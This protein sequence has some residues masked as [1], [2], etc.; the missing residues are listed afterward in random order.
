MT[1]N[2]M[3]GVRRWRARLALT[4]CA[5]VA[6]QL[7]ALQS[8]SPRGRAPIVR[9]ADGFEA[10][11]GEALVQFRD[12]PTAAR[13]RGPLADYVDAA[14]S[15]SV[16]RRGLHRFRSRTFDVDALVA[17]LRTQPDVVFAEPN[18]VLRAIATPN[19]QH[20]P[21]LWGLFN[22]GQVV[23]GVMGVPGADISATDAWD[24]STG[25]RDTV[26]AVIDTG[27]D[28]AHPDLAANLWSA[29]ASFTVTVG[30]L[31][32]TCP[33]G[34]HGFN[35]ITRS[36]NPQDD[37]YHGTHVAGTIGAVGNNGIGVAG[38]NWTAS[39]IGVK[40]LDSGGSGLVDDAV[41]GLEF[42]TQT[43]A[44]FAASGAA[45]IRVLNNSWGGGPFSQALD[46]AIGLTNS[47]DML[48]IAA[49]GN[50]GTNNDTL[51]F[52]PANYARPNVLSIA[53]T[54]SS[55]TI[56]SFSNRGVSTVDLAAPGVNI[57]STVPGN[58]YAY[59]SGTSMAAP[60][61]SGAAALVLSK[62]TL[63]TAALK[64]DLLSTVDVLGSL[65]G[66]VASS[67]RLNAD[68]ALR[69]CAVPA[70]PTGLVA[71]PG[72][73]RVTLS[74][75]PAIRASSYRVKRA[76]VSG[77]PYTTIA[78]GVS[79]ASYLDTSG[80]N[81]GV[82]YHYVV[83][84]V[85][86]AGDGPNSSQA[87]AT[88]L[89]LK[90]PAPATLKAVPGDARVTLTWPASA[91]ADSYNVKRSPVSG[92][93]FVTIANVAATSYVDQGVTNG[94]VY[95]YRVTALNEAGESLPSKKVGVMPAPVPLAPSGV[96]IAAGASPGVVNLSWNASA[97]ATSYKVKRATVSGGP[98]SSGKKA[99]TTA[100][101]ETVTSGRRYYYVVTA[102][103]AS[104]ESGL[105]TQVT[106]VAP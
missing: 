95:Y 18:Y 38:V 66:L 105:S 43:K 70:A 47:A 82:T 8:Q 21:L 74:W 39:L 26:V 7:A 80:V 17:F 34:S 46:D 53:A 42:L 98:Y 44:A 13:Q 75:N 81:N 20:F 52:Y 65:S 69:T 84:G 73:A 99:L 59:L 77:G 91:G 101:S 55:D 28:L 6:M 62:C 36:C 11:G 93:P 56:A 41:E 37:H 83:T 79:T 10:A 87:S 4:I 76:T 64:S 104:G 68:R 9:T 29:P 16:G 92:G 102:V 89:A 60:H 51:P 61:V 63:T 33:A 58:A 54:G 25:S 12:A 15:S 35:A 5:V 30:G 72:D 94:T 45:N 48:F 106:I 97:W 19:D 103:N 88:P 57:A 27:I 67:G 23:N 86:V 100:Y 40:F 71:T 49:A 78:S 31:P 14:E 22:N 32:L 2:T 1:H 50:S 24:V 3:R 90:P 96:T 85:N